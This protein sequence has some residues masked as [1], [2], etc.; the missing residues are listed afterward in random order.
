M[1]RIGFS[2]WVIFFVAVQSFAQ[3]PDKKYLLGKFDPASDSRFTALKGEHAHSGGL[4]R[5]E[6][7]AAFVKMAHA[8]RQEK[9][10]LIIISSTRD[11][12]SQKRIWE[13][14]WNGKTIVEGKDLTT[15]KDPVER[16]RIILHYS[17]MPGTSRHHWGTDMD[18]NS[19]ENAYFE[20]GEGQRIYKWLLKHAGE[21][22][23]CQPYTNKTNAS[24]TART[25]YEEEKWHWSYLPLSKL[26]LDEYVRLIQSSDISGFAGAE[27]AGAVGIIE[28][29]VSGVNCK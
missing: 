20:T 27:T 12:I 10:N 16:A 7:Y 29:Y 21:Y 24:G 26:F 6:V 9:I 1:R 2:C 14:K 11:F 18:L 23:F 17:S 5:K 25:G 22:G 4:L 28:E 8:A 13:N 3:A 19:L 15:V